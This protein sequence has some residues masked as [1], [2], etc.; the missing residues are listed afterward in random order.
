MGSLF[1]NLPVLQG[2]CCHIGEIPNHFFFFPSVTF[3][4]VLSR[5]LLCF[6]SPIV[7][8]PTMCSSGTLPGSQHPS[9]EGNAGLC[10]RVVGKKRSPPPSL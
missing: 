3:L 9:L 8:S 5:D 6:H 10:F 7:A 4:M 1:G 2:K